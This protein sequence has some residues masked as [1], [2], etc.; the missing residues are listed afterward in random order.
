MGTPEFEAFAKHY[1]ETYKF[2]T[3]TSADFKATLLDFF[4]K[5]PAAPPSMLG[6]LGWL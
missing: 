4:K 6:G 1:V 2:Q 5:V 3:V